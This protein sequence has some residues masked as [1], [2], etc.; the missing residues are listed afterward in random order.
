MV[1]LLLPLLVVVTSVATV[2]GNAHR[3]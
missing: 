2:D 1:F 3:D